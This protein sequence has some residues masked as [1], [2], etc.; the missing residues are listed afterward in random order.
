MRGINHRLPREMVVI[1][2][3]I[4]CEILN[5]LKSNARISM[6]QLANQIFMSPPATCERVRKLMDSGVICGYGVR[7]DPVKIGLPVRA[8][9]AITYTSMTIH[10]LADIIKDDPRVTQIN[11]LMGHTIGMLQVACTN[12][13][14]L[15]DLL[16]K[17]KQYCVT[18]TY[19]ISDDF[20][21]FEYTI[22]PDS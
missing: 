8:F 12:M 18:E 5:I 19:V 3:K 21:S 9:V 6:R 16:L 15:N 2:D 11:G 17:L 20:K 10:D 14:N 1:M 22:V 4:D 7:F 13:E